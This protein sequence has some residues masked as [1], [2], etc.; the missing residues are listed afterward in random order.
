MGRVALCPPGHLSATYGDSDFAGPRQ[1]GARRR[2]R[3]QDGGSVI[4]DRTR[5]GCRIVTVEAGS[6]AALPAQHRASAGRRGDS[7]IFRRNAASARRPTKAS[8]TT[9]SSSRPFVPEDLEKIEQSMRALA[10]QDLPYERQMWPRDE[11]HRLFRE[12]GE[13]L[14]VQLIDEKTEGQNE[15]SCYTIKDRETFVDFCVGPHVPSTG[16]LKAFKLLLDVERLL[17]GR[18]AQPADAAHLRHRVP[19]RQGSEGVSHADRG[20]RRSATTGA[21]AATSASSPFIRGRRAPRS[22]SAKARRSTTRS[23]TTCATCSSPPATS[24]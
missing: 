8:S 3:R 1:S 7:I 13:P 9:S 17:E 6:A 11:G 16:K 19:H 14:K 12:R 15:V 22:G 4:S 10:N 23:P 18:R 5:R 2:D 21:S 20:S 24:R